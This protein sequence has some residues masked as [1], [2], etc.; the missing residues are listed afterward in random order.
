LFGFPATN[1]VEMVSLKDVHQMPGVPSHVRGVMNL[2]GQVI[3]VID[4][5]LYFG[6]PSARQ[7]LDDLVNIFDAREQDHR[8]WMD[9]LDTAIRNRTEFKLALDPHKCAF[10]RWYDSLRTDDVV[11]S[12][13]LRKIDAPHQRIHQRGAEA[14]ACLAQN[15]VDGAVRIAEDI[16]A[17][18]MKVTL[19]L[20]AES[21]A[22][23]REAQREIAIVMRYDA[24]PFAAAVDGVESVEHLKEADADEAV[25]LVQQNGS[26]R[27]TAI[28]KRARDGTL[29]MLMDLGEVAQTA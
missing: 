9:A 18:E 8:R 5:R 27:L 16:R 25:T 14:L 22:V 4:L 1:V 23:L 26:D 29:V 10:G 7:A 13:Q 3:P 6:M 20:F 12:A 24:R 28:R 19:G 11:L 21:K 17:R 2:R 15:D